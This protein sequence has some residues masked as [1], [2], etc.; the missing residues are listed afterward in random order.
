MKKKIVVGGIV[1]AIAAVAAIAVPRALKKNAP[2]EEA[3]LPVVDVQTPETGTIELFRELVGSVEPSDVVYI[4]PKMA[5]E[6]TEVFVKAGD[7]V[8][9]GQ[10]ICTIDTKQVDAARLS[11]ESAA[12]AQT[13]LARQQAL[14]QAGDIASVMLEQAQTA[15]K[16]AQ[17]Q[18]DSAKLNYDHQMEYANI[19]ATISGKVEI[20]DIEVHDN[21]SQQNLIT[22]I[23]G[24]GSKSVSF[25]VPE[26]IAE[27]LR[28]GDPVFI[29]KNGSE[30][31]GTINEISSMIDAATGLF[32]VKASVEDGDALATGSAVQLKVTSD[33]QE[34]VMTL[35]VDTVY[36]SGGDAY[37]YLY[38]DGTVHQVPVEVGIYDSERVQILSGI[39]MTDEVITTWSS[40]LYEGSQVQKSQAGSAEAEGSAA[41]QTDAENTGAAEAAKAE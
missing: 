11:L 38:E 14:F 15:A 25:A 7:V 19:T 4:Y 8:E 21:V 17:I 13:N 32:Q 36:Y 34:N 27:Q 40:E 16:N 6:V 5:G 3:A 35:P 26:K 10:P 18:Y 31:T 41:D 33:K 23:A 39:D 2:V 28:A 22:V 24:E 37:L 12:Q 30:Y 9:E 20:C 1:V 29:E